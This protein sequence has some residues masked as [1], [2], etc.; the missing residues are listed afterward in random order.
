MSTVLFFFN[1]S[2][3]L[4]QVNGRGCHIGGSVGTKFLGTATYFG[5]TDQIVQVYSN[6]MLV[7]II[8]GNG[9]AGYR[10]G[11][12]NVYDSGKRNTPTQNDVPYPAAKEIVNN[13]SGMASHKCVTVTS[14]SSDVTSIKGEGYE[15][16][17]QYNDLAYSAY[18]DPNF[19]CA[20]QPNSLPVDDYI[21]YLLATVSLSGFLLVRKKERLNFL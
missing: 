18:A 20:S 10:C 14:Y 8:T 21:P 13:Y 5:H 16:D 1:I 7:P 3:S 6:S 12:I 4:S 15:V 11:Y 19:P 2:Q 9:F 17:Y